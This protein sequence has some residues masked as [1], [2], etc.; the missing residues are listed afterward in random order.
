MTGQ[1]SRRPT[2][3]PLPRSLDPLPDETLPGYL[4]RLAHRLG[5]APARIMQLTGLTA[6]RDGREPARRSL[7]LHLDEVPAGAFTRVTR[8][9]AADTAGLCMSSMSGQ[10]P[11]AAPRV[12]A[13][14]WGPRSLAS[15]W[16]FISATRYCPQCLAGDGSPIQQEHGGAWQKAWRLPVVFA[17]PVHRRLLEHLCPSCLQPAMS[18]APGAPAWLIPRAHHG[19]L[20][21]AQCRAAPG[22]RAAGRHARPCGARLDAPA[23]PGED[24]PAPDDLLTLQDRLLPLL[25][26]KDPPAAMSVGQLATPAQYFADLRLVCSLINGTWPH[27]ADLIAG[28]GLAECLGRHIASTGGDAPRRHTLC[29]APPLNA[30]PGAALITAAVRIL[31]CDDLR[32]LGELL[33]PA[34]DDASRKGPRGRWIRRYQRAGHGCSD[35]LRDALEPLINSFQRADRRSRGRRAPA[36]QIAFAPEHI[37][38]HL[39]DDWYDQHFRCIG[40]NTRLLRRAA[41][42]R[43]VQM[44]AGGSLAE[45]AAFLGIDHRYLKASPGSA[46]F[47]AGGAELRLAVHALARQL[48]T[49]PG[50]INYKQRRDA[51][52]DWCIDPAAWQDIISQ[53]PPTKGP[54][55]P[56]LSHCKRQFASEAVWAR[57]TQGEHLLAPRIIGDQL[58]AADPIWHQRR[59]NMWHCYLASPAKPHYAALRKILNAHADRLAAVIDHQGGSW[60]PA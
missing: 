36:A 25:S 56:E 13:D 34:R 16:V 4:L 29:D 18:A 31:D 17:C 39:Q 50:L 35:G 44:S 26:P 45:A 51:L 59:D 8:L 12:T 3:S 32:V 9:T 60:G 53:L 58:S 2:L 19:G 22:P 28:P 14:Q 7:M 24:P 33:A 43:L 46:A 40:G 30:R 41:A 11:W 37:P 27:S 54:F 23:R 1:D 49:T 38:E 42:L 6:G 52:Q 15:P 57:I 55:R 20:H 21:P 48:S 10:Y 5:L 47:A